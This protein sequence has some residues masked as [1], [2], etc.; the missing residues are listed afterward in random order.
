MKTPTINIKELENFKKKNFQE[1]LEFIDK[2]T[3][4]LK[5]NQNK[6]WSKQQKDFID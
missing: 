5:K 2:Y 6:K 3:E 4:W 1:R